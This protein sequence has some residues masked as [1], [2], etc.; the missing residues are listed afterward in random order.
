MKKYLFMLL[1]MVTVAFAFTS[2]GDDDDSVYSGRSYLSIYDPANELTEAQI[3][4]LNAMIKEVGELNIDNAESSSVFMQKVTDWNQKFN[5]KLKDYIVAYPEVLETKQAG[6]KLVS[7]GFGGNKTEMHT[8]A[9]MKKVIED[10]AA[11]KI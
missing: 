10:A 11:G 1:A 8:F 3:A 5:T 7:S 9:E 2:C 6:I 4:G